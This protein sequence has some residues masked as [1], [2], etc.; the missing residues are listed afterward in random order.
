MYKNKVKLNSSIKNP[1]KDIENIGDTQ[2]RTG[3]R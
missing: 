1:V 2:N 3:G